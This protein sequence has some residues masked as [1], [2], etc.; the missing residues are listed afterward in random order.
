MN[1][2]KILYLHG[3]DAVPS[4]EK[5]SILSEVFDCEVLAP[6]QDYYASENSIEL[7]GCFP[8]VISQAKVVVRDIVDL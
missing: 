6:K 5:V 2:N 8:G 4:N 7:T 1:V 3:L